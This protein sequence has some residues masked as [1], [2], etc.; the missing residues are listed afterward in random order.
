MPSEIILPTAMQILARPKLKMH[1][2]KIQLY[3]SK[4]FLSLWIY[5]RTANSII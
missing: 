3:F 2:F 5:T 1:E 4:H